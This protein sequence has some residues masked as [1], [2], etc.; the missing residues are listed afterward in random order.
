MN[1]LGQS[2][3]GFVGPASSEKGGAESGQSGNLLSL[4]GFLLC[5]FG[6]GH[7]LIVWNRYRSQRTDPRQRNLGEIRLV[8]SEGFEHSLTLATVRLLVVGA[9][10]ELR[11]VGILSYRTIGERD[12]RVQIDRGLAPLAEFGTGLRTRRVVCSIFWLQQNQLT[13]MVFGGEPQ[14]DSQTFGCRPIVPRPPPREPDV[15]RV[16][17]RIL[18]APQ[19]QVAVEAAR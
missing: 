12:G 18:D 8:A 13:E 1:R 5:A 14:P 7:Q 15:R 4:R 6:V 10:M 3:D 2:F 9:Q 11:P 17:R 16:G 19:P